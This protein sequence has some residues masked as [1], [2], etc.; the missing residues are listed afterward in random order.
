M[1]VKRAILALISLCVFAQIAVVYLFWGNAPSGDGPADLIG[2]AKR[3]AYLAEISGCIACHTDRENGGAFLAGGTKLVSGMG[4]FY[5]PNIT[6]DKNT[7]IGQ[8]DIK[9]FANAVK[10]GLTPDGLQYYPVFPYWAY[11]D[12]T[13]QDIAD[14][15]AAFRTS[16]PSG[17]KTAEQ[18]PTFPLRNRRLVNSWIRVFG[19]TSG[20]EPR[21]D[22]S[23][24][25]NRGAFIANGLG[26]CKACHQRRNVFFSWTRKVLFP[27][28]VRD[29][30]LQQI[31]DISPAALQQRGWDRARLAAAL[32]NGIKAHEDTNGGVLSAIFTD[33]TK[34]L[35][36]DDLNNL[37]EYLLDGPG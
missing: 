31:P 37:A 27:D 2:D 30:P 8:W 11:A 5:P 32:R 28:K 24:S 3:G 12:F 1:T 6:S 10:Q 7:G 9:T 22:K 15:W 4:V 29:A 23:D 25:W 33:V 18:Q 13:D 16:T 14:L 19:N 17:F 34:R 35:S 26:A 36:E 21:K 20:F